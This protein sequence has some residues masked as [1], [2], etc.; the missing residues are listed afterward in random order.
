MNRS[1]CNL[2]KH[3]AAVLNIIVI[4]L[5][6]PLLVLFASATCLCSFKVA[7]LAS[8]TCMFCFFA[9]LAPCVRK[10][11]FVCR[12][13]DVKKQTCFP[14]HAET[15]LKKRTQSTW[16]N[17]VLLFVYCELQPSYNTFGQR[18]DEELHWFLKHIRRTAP[19]QWRDKSFSAAG[20]R[21]GHHLMHIPCMCQG[22]WGKIRKIDAE[23]QLARYV[24]TNVYV[25]QS[26]K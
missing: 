1:S 12:C 11:F 22:S 20:S 2:P 26:K 25:Q 10:F 15:N 14:K 18:T 4:M 21:Q 13:E 6:P 23:I 16:N 7:E 9:L 19:L 8:S 17:W 24:R 3:C 5:V